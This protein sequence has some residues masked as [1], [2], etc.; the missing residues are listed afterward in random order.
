MSREGAM[1]KVRIM[2][3]KDIR[4]ASSSLRRSCPKGARRV[5]FEESAVSSLHRH[6]VVLDC[7]V[8]EVRRGKH[9]PAWFQRYPG[10]AMRRARPGALGNQKVADVDQHLVG[11]EANAHVGWFRRGHGYLVLPMPLSS[12]RASF[13]LQKARRRSGWRAF[14]SIAYWL[15]HQCSFG[16][17][18][19]LT[20]PR[21]KCPRK[22]DLIS[23]MPGGLTAA[24]RDG[25]TIVRAGMEEW[26]C[27]GPNKR[28]APNWRT[29]CRQTRY[30][31][32]KLSPSTK[33]GQVHT[34]SNR[35][36]R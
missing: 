22:A 23:P 24:A 25:R 13:I 14:I 4:R 9:A 5:G 31:D 27:R 32:P 26:L 30:P 12:N 16:R 21:R 11:V 35:H 33:S 10:P 28:M 7:Q 20:C 1:P 19:P 18:M 34:A 6:A 36:G 15:V 17:L 2:S 3:S 8:L 29:K